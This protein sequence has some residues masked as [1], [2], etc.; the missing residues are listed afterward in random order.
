VNEQ[1]TTFKQIDLLSIR[2]VLFVYETRTHP[3]VCKYLLSTPPV[4]YL[5]HMEWLNAN[6]PERRKIFLLKIEGTIIGYC[7][8]Y[9]FIGKDTV[10]IGFVVHPEH[11][12][13]G[14][15]KRMVVEIT[16]WLKE[17]MPD[18]KIILYVR[19]GNDRAA[20]LYSRCGFKAKEQVGESLRYEME[21]A[22]IT[23]LDIAFA[24]DGQNPMMLRWL[25]YLSDG[26]REAGAVS[27]IVNIGTPAGRS[28]C[29]RSDMVLF[30]R[31]TQ[32]S[33]YDF[34]KRMKARKKFV[35]YF[36]DDYLFQPDC[37]YSSG[38][39]VELLRQMQLADVVASS[40]KRLLEKVKVPEERKVFRRTVMD[41]ATF[42]F[43]ASDSPK[44]DGVWR[45][46]YLAGPARK[47]GGFIQKVLAHLDPLIPERQSVV[48]SCFGEHGLGT[49]RNISVNKVPLFL[50][51]DWKGL[52]REYKN[53]FPNVVI[54]V[55]DETDEFCHCKSEL[56]YV[57]TSALGV[58]LVTSRV[59]PFTEVI[60]DGENG[61]LA[62]TPE[63]FAEK[64]LMLCKNS[65]LA[66]KVSRKAQEH[67]RNEYDVVRNARQ[68]IFDLSGVRTMKEKKPQ[69]VHTTSIHQ[70]VLSDSEVVGPITHGACLEMSIP[71]MPAMRIKGIS[72]I[73]A[74]YLK[75]PHIPASWQVW[76]NGQKARDGS[77]LANKLLDNQRW[78]IG[79]ETVRVGDGDTLTFRLINNDAD[80]NLALYASIEKSIGRARL[81]VKQVRPISMRF[82]LEQEGKK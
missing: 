39:T 6:V 5:A 10:E 41:R 64:V 26:I 8:V 55:L 69:E 17:N 59:K 30:Y 1:Y 22:R 7:Q 35:V 11:Q 19:M 29:D 25:G 77:I 67:V 23:G 12:G 43:L 71:V 65:G 49:F 15:G 14:Y 20:S 33:S 70:L 58:P 4:S 2:D 37:K 62:S 61:F 36:I 28:R 78:S 53:L 74:T 50:Q 82:E 13:K 24:H 9:D 54:N 63:E 44:K 73:G 68:F 16:A 46:G 42:D 76:V 72:V 52:Y 57:E 3:E 21:D 45:I 18:R 75:V 51:E 66:E 27:E 32:V 31:T 79:F 80:V 47:M 56:K 81:G 40:S 34:M 60:K 48:F 38:S